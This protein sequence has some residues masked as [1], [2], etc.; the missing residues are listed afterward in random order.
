MIWH[1]VGHVGVVVM[2]TQT[3]EAGR[4]KC[5]QY[6]PLNEESRK[7]EVIESDGLDHFAGTVELLESNFD[8]RTRSTVRKLSLTSE[9]A[10]KLVWH[11]LFEGWPDFSIPDFDDRRALVELTKDSLKKAR[12][13]NNAR[14]VHCSAGV[15]RSGTFIALDYLLGEL[16]DGALDD[17]TDEDDPIAGTVNELRKQR[18]M[19]VQG[20]AQFDFLY[21]VMRELWFAQRLLP[22]RIASPTL[23]SEGEEFLDAES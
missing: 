6:F 4:E 7:L 8:D 16:A 3:H 14:V 13:G 23:D 18:M 22:P 19:M 10:T 15:G 20:E 21:D 1:E 17:V 5:F 9:G 12:S 11:Y 2:L